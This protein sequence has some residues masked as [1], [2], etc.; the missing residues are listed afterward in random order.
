MWNSGDITADSLYWQEGFDEWLPLSDLKELLEERPWGP[1]NQT[2]S[3]SPQPAEKPIGFGEMICMLFV[4]F[5]LAIAGFIAGLYYITRP[6]KKKRGAWL[7]GF[8]VIGFFFW[9]IVLG[10]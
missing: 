3:F 7:I 6:D 1:I 2:V 9:S 4:G 10:L 5:G 8:S